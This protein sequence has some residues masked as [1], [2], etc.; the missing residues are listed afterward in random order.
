MDEVTEAAFSGESARFGACYADDATAVTPDAGEL[1]GRD[2]IVGWMR[3]FNEAMPDL[4]WEELAKHEA[5][6]VAID[7]GYVVGT[8]TGPLAMPTGEAL[9]ATGKKIRVRG[10]D[11][12]VVEDGRITSHRF[13]YDQMEFLGQLGLLPEESAVTA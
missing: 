9:P 6:N 11:I 3:E 5:G 2:A 12:A 4:R 7:E 13:Y 10:C 1:R 8:H